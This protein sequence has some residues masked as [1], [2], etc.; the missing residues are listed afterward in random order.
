M[1]GR[2]NSHRNHSVALLRCPG[3]ATWLGTDT[4]RAPHL[5]RGLGTAECNRVAHCPW[6]ALTGNLRG[7][8]ALIL[9]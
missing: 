5:P 7:T 6:W 8:L 2:G 3:G 4:P 9:P 1:R